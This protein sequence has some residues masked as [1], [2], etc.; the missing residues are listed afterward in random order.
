MRFKKNNLNIASE[1]R[2]CVALV[3]TCVTFT[4][5]I[6][7][8]IEPPR[9]QRMTTSLSGHLIGILFD[10]S[11]LGLQVYISVQGFDPAPQ[12]EPIP[13]L[14]LPEEGN[15]EASK[16]CLFLINQSETQA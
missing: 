6:S 13:K 5:H 12:N 14:I 1:R 9:L 16:I 11:L 7:P 8:H 4:G 15:K 10:A 2:L 3:G